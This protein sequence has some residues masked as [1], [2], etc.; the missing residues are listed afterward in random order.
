L[1]WLKQSVTALCDALFVVTLII[2]LSDLTNSPLQVGLALVAL[3]APYALFGPFAE[4]ATERWSRRRTMFVTDVVRGL[5]TFFLCA[6]VLPVFTP[7]RALAVIY[8]LCFCIGLMSR[9]SLAAQRS[10]ITAVVRPS[11][12]PRGISRIQGSV[13]IMTIAG[14]IL[15]AMLFLML[16]P[17]PIPGLIVAG[18]LLLLSAGG[19]QAMDQQFTAKVRAVQA[20]RRRRAADQDAE[21]E[22]D[23][24]AAEEDEEESWTRSVLRSGIADSVKGIRLAL[25]QRPFGTIASIV[26][27]IA[28]VGG[29]FNVLEVFFVSA[30][31]GYP[32]AYL[33]LLVGANAAGVLLGSVWF[34]QL[35]AHV[36]PITT[37]IYTV[38]GMGLTTAGFISSRSLSIAILWA[39]AMGLTNG[40]A[41]LAAQTALVETGERKYFSRLSVGYETLT[42]LLGN[43]GI[44]LGSVAALSISI[45]IILG[46]ASGLVIFA[47]ISAWL[48]LSGRAARFKY[49]RA[50][51]RNAEEPESDFEPMEEGAEGYEPGEGEPAE[52]EAADFDE[53]GEQEQEEEQP[54]YQPPSRQFGRRWANGASSQNGANY[55]EAEEPFYEEDGAQDDADQWAPAEP[56]EE[57][58]APRRSL[59]LRPWEQSGGPGR[60]R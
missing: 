25:R 23:A 27:L 9:F 60:S 31:L 54:M 10:A 56:I 50:A 47:G 30:Y 26:A 51:A 7:R 8:L 16:G 19:A 38:L 36:S 35:D 34:R 15:A 18:F 49:R 28:F 52:E 17:T 41:L 53:A 11:E 29:T 2:W 44:L 24:E 22:P 55:D 6:T 3:G 39:A 48:V 37:F 46:V 1:L 21:E 13:A 32:G 58:P 40:M 20:R 5:L 12:H 45:G 42:A 4:A 57:P 14:P 43:V 33:G 59:R